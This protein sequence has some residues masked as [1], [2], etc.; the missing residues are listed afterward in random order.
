MSAKVEDGLAGTADPV[1]LGVGEPVQARSLGDRLELFTDQ[2]PV[3]QVRGMFTVAA[4]TKPWSGWAPK[5][6]WS[7]RG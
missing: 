7:D 4:A 3:G 2:E 5:R 1:L 6:K